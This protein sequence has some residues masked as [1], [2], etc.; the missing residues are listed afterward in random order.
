MRIVLL[1]VF[2]IAVSSQLQAQLDRSVFFS[3]QAKTFLDLER[4]REAEA[5]ADSALMMAV[6]SNMPDSISN[7]YRLRYDVFLAGKNYEKALHDFRLAIVYRDSA[8]IRNLI[9]REVSR[10]QIQDSLIAGF[11]REILKLHR[12]SDQYR[13]LAEADRQ[14]AYPILIGILAIVTVVVLFIYRKYQTAQQRMKLA[15]AEIVRLKELRQKLYDILLKEMKMISAISQVDEPT[16]RDVA[17]TLNHILQWIGYQVSDPDSDVTQ[18]DCRTL[19]EEVLR[20]FSDRLSKDNIRADIFIPEGLMV[21]A[22]RSMVTIVLENLMLNALDFTRP[23]GTVTIFSGKKD[24]LVTMGVKDSGIGMSDEFISQLFS[25]RHRATASVTNHE[26]LGI[27]LLLCRDLI[28][29]NGGKLYVESKEGMGSTF[30]FSLPGNK[31]I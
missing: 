16:S 14:S 6:R 15:E 21:P 27:G 31:T 9:E 5:Y 10:N 8:V 4:Y 26:G 29:Q 1:L 17:E 18:F 2:F 24:E 20:K 12:E 19:A 22:D 11:N 3:R 28:E 30:Y 7:A 13:D 25:S 23:G